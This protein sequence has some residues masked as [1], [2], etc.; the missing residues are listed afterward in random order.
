MPMR[1][2]TEMPQLVGATEWING[3]PNIEPGKVVLVHFWAVSCHICH[4][5]MPEVLR[6]RDEY[7]DHGLCTVAVHMPRMQEDTE[8]SRVQ[9]DIERY[10]I[11]QPCAIDNEHKLANA[12]SNEY[13]PA[14]FVFGKDGTLTFRAAGDKGFAKVEPKVREALGLASS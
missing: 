3:E 13:T 9:A 1:L 12:F 2:G 11:T 6:L 4:E 8:I 7:A 10:H 5:T 14:F